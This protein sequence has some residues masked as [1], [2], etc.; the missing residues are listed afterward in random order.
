M[1]LVIPT[2]LILNQRGMYAVKHIP[3]V[4]SH[5]LDYIQTTCQESNKVNICIILVFALLI[6][7]ALIFN[8]RRKNDGVK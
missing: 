4:C 2:H 5:S 8:T 3:F 1:Q 7:Y 6:Q